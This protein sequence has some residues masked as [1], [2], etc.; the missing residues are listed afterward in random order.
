MSTEH[1]YRFP[2]AAF[3]EEQ[4]NA[5]HVLKKEHALWVLNM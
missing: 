2:Y 5:E 1:S 4:G 3:T